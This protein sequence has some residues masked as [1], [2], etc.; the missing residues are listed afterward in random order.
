MSPGEKGVSFVT[1]CSLSKNAFPPQVGVSLR[2]VL[3]ISLHL[4][5]FLVFFF[6]LVSVGKYP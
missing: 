1:L 2:R 5:D 3:E 4:A 6:T